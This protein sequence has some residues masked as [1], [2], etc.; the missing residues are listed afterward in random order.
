MSQE[1]LQ[2]TI[3]SFRKLGYGIVRTKNKAPVVNNWQFLASDT[4][5]WAGNLTTAR[6]AG[7][8]ISKDIVVVDVDPRNFNEGVDSLQELSKTIGFDLIKN[9]GFSVKT[10]SGGYHLYYKKRPEVRLPNTTEQFKGVE[11]KQKGQQVVLPYS[12]LP[13]NREYKIIT[14]NLEQLVELPQKFYDVIG[15]KAQAKAVITGAGFNDNP[16]DIHRMR[17]LLANV[18]PA[19]EGQNGDQATFRVCCL[20]KDY[21]LSPEVFFDLLC[22]WNEKCEPAWDLNELRKKMINAYSYSHNKAGSHSIENLF[23]AIEDNFNTKT[24]TPE[25]AKRQEESLIDWQNELTVCKNGGYHK[26]LKNAV[27]FIKHDDNLKGRLAF[28]QFSGDKVWVDSVYWH[29]IDKEKSFRPNGRMWTDT[30]AIETRYLLNNYAFDI[31]TNLIFEAVTKVANLN[32]YHPVKDWLNNNCEWD[33]T[34]RLDT[35]F[36]KYCGADDNAYSKEVARKMFC[37]IV[38]RVFDPGC[39]FDYL[40]IFVGKQGIGKSTLLKVISIHPSWFCDNIGDITNAKEVIPQTR[41]KLIV[42]WQELALFSKIDINHSKSFLS[43]SVDRVR[44]AYHREAKDYPRQFIVVAT[45][46]QDKFLLDET[47][48]RRM[49]PIELRD[50]DTTAVAKDLQQIYAE[51]LQLYRKGEKLYITDEEAVNI[52][53]Q[54]QFDRFRNDELEEVIIDWLDNIPE[55]CKHFIS[56][57]KIQVNDLI[58]HCLKETPAKARGLANRIGNILRRLGYISQS[59]RMDGKVKY[60]F[61][62]KI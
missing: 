45:T 29:N 20:G 6:E 18:P 51:A 53:K 4:S 62:K 43:T 22:E 46:N 5:L 27:L 10:A 38:A 49:L 58:I 37:A 61:V 55:D 41:G 44:E 16:A 2:Q 42:E 23:N 56:K 32:S 35:F 31:G 8:V 39:K 14:D 34:K 26:T 3:T 19:I 50:I 40:P 33:G 48:N 54:I 7:F 30:D 25:E 1:L 28:N 21:G 36:H 59:Y 17:Q 9:A 11:F 12:V 57:E 47:G 24:L 13:D 52:A 60:G 15:T